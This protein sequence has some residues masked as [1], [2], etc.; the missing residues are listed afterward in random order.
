MQARVEIYYRMKV[1]KNLMDFF[2]YV[3]ALKINGSLF[4]NVT[5]CNFDRRSLTILLQMLAMVD[6]TLG[7]D[8]RI[9]Y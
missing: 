9:W 3:Y 5:C 8:F 7:Y 1:N 2:F 4:M 6:I